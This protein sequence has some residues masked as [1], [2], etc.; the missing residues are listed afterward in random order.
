MTEKVSLYPLDF[1]W[2]RGTSKSIRWED[3][4]VRAGKCR[5]KI[6][7]VTW[8]RSFHGH[9]YHDNLGLLT[10]SFIY[11]FPLPRLE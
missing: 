2:E 4:R 7:N 10:I 5:L 8:S 9:N 1:N 3:Q 6:L 11:F